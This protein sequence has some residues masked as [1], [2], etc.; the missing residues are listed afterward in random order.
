MN[1]Y[2][3]PGYVESLAE[4]GRPRSL[5]RCGGWLLE[6]PIPGTTAHDAMG[7]YPLFACR[8]WS[9][10][11]VDLA[12]LD[13]ELVSVVLV[14]DPFGGYTQEELQKSFDVLV[15]FKEHFIVDLSQPLSKALSTNHREKA[16]RGLRAVTIECCAEPIRLLDEWMVQYE[17]LIERH[18]IRGI[19]AFS[20][21]AFARQL[22]IPGLVMFRAL[23]QGE[24]VGATLWFCQGEIG[25]R[26]LA[27]FDDHGYALRASYALD[28]Q[29]IEYF[30]DQKLRWLH[31]G[32]GAGVKSDG[33]DG[34][35]FYKRGWSTGSVPAY[36][37]GR[38]LDRTRYAEIV[39]TKR[40]GATTYFPAYRAGEFG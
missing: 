36:F 35:S 4:F 18:Q 11:A 33:G 19:S 28:W 10:L 23:Y 15:P 2:L 5:P 29:A 30:A 21:P 27:A 31:L 3:H 7:C 39:A 40:I 17:R 22:T 14:A 24:S 8:D 38:I 26:H 6:R 20:R 32:G 25:Y 13:S 12:T 34:L 16:R 1:G 37:C 9:Q